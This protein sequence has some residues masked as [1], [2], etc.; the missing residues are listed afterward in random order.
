MMANGQDSSYIHKTDSSTI[1]HISIFGAKKHNLSDNSYLLF[2]ALDKNFIF[3]H[4]VTGAGLEQ[5]VTYY[6]NNT[7]SIWKVKAKLGY[8]FSADRL[9][10]E[11]L[12][13]LNTKKQHILINAGKDFADWKGDIGEERFTNSVIAFLYNGNYKVLYDRTFAHVCYT[14]KPTYGLELSSALTTEH[15]GSEHNR[16]NLSLFHKKKLFDPNIPVNSSIDHCSISDGRQTTLSFKA[17]Y[18]PRTLGFTND[19]G[20]PI[21]LGSIYPSFS[22]GAEKGLSGASRYS[23]INV[24]VFQ[25][26]ALKNDAIWKWEI[27]GGAFFNSDNTRF[28]QWKHFCGSN[29]LF[30]LSS[31]I[32]G[33]IGFVMFRP[34]ELSTNKW[35]TSVRTAYITPQLILKE[36][37]L[38]EDWSFKEELYLKNAVINGNLSFTEF[39]YGVGNVL[40]ILRMT[41]FISFRNSSFDAVKFRMAIDL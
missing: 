36:I 1:V 13:Q 32:D 19:N 9:T 15:I 3:Y 34:Y 22:L 14:T 29:K 12:T 17:V 40:D 38:F 24:S 35:Y 30:A 10:G 4:P 28:S 6:K 7:S 37:E 27:E 11:L 16:S 21:C 18:T 23:H 2:S 20:F 41:A 5:S 8:A 39:G 25:R 33:Y 31:D 26:L